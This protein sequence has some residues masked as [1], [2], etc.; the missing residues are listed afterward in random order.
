MNPAPP[1]RLLIVDDESAQVV[2]L[3]RTL[4]FEGYAT[5]GAGSGPEALSALRTAA[6]DRALRLRRPHYRPH[7]A[8]YGRHRAA[9]R[10]TGDRP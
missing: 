5:T 7:D 8:G 3:C 6:A 2:A 10:G 1:A 4:A 9:A